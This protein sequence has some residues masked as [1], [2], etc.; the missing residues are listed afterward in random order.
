[1]RTKKPLS[2]VFKPLRDGIEVP[3]IKTQGSAGA[4][5][6]V[7]DDVIIEPFSI[8]GKGTLVPLGFSLD[9]PEGMQVHIMLR[10]SVGLNTPLRL[11]NGVGLIDSDYKGE[12]CLLLDNLSKNSINIKS[13]TR[14]AQLV[15]FSTLKWGFEL[16]VTHT[17]ERKHINPIQNKKRSGGFGSTTE[18]KET[19]ANEN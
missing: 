8:R 14:I 3:Q 4:D 6:V 19:K 11:S 15:P 17:E 9:I 1:M 10:S 13:G 7:P 2:I 18:T 5:L 12:I 16:I